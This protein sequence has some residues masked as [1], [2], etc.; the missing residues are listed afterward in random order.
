MISNHLSHL[1][2][3]Q[4]NLK[5]NKTKQNKTKQNK[6]KQNNNQRDIILSEKETVVSWA[7]QR[8]NHAGECMGYRSNRDPS[9]LH[10]QP[11]RKDETQTS[12]HVSH[13]RRVILHGGL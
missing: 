2:T 13:Q 4:R 7:S 6:I 10:T 5:Q 9:G 3:Q 11:R 12:L 1:S 8:P